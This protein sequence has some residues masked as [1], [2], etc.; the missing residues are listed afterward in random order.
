MSVQSIGVDQTSALRRGLAALFVTLI[1]VVGFSNAL[2][3]LARRWTQQEEYSHGFLIPVVAAWL[4]WTRREVLRSSLGPPVWAGPGMMLLAV[5]MHIMGELSATLI[6]SQV[7]FVLALVGL[8]LAIGGYSLLRATGIPILFLLFAIPAPHFVD[9]TISLRL[10][11]ISSQLGAALIR[12]F[13][14]PVYRDGNIIDLGYYSLQVADACSGLRYMY[15]LLSL[16]FLA[17][18]L[19]RAP[20]WQRAI[21]FFSS[22]PITIAM[23]SIRIGLVGVTVDYWGAQAA[24]G[25][26]HF[27]EGWVVFLACAGILMLEIYVLTRIS[28]K[29][30]SEVFYIAIPSAKPPEKQ[31]AKSTDHPKLATSLLLLCAAGM[32]AF[33]I[34]SRSETIPDRSRFVTFPTRIGL[35]QGRA[36]L[37]DPEVERGL[38]GLNDY[39][40]SDYKESDG[41]VVNLY[42]AYYASQKNGQQPHSPNDCIPAN[43][44]RITQLEPISYSENGAELSLN[45]AIIEKNSI[46]ELVYYWFDERGR[47]IANEYLAKW[48]LRV[49]AIFMN[50]TDGALVRLVTEIQSDETEGEADQRLKAFIRD[51]L[52]KLSDYLP[53]QTPSQAGPVQAEPKSTRL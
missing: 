51:A 47:K 37:L 43:G 52:P 40:L 48:Y 15:P 2:L 20:I 6:L 11:I 27:F 36:S 38:A 22:I 4:L 33:F 28:G 23:N 3:E 42:V 1:A 19:F 12:M 5:T 53:D 10:Q 17:A 49:D 29:A 25:F 44:W 7:G 46:K 18:Y 24:D 21:V 45:R 50:R 9:S 39:L 41:K 30:L 26:I 8:V 35:W 13:Q 14:I 32:A 16:S 34:S 31:Q